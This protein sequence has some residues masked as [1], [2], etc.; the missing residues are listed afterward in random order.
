[1]GIDI[2]VRIESTLVLDRTW[3]GDAWNQ[4][5][6]ETLGFFCR[7]LEWIRIRAKRVSVSVIVQVIHFRSHNAHGTHYHLKDQNLFLAYSIYYLLNIEKTTK[8][9]FFILKKK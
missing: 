7:E 3:S 8:I 6:D 4:S 5:L 9:I 2:G 1:M